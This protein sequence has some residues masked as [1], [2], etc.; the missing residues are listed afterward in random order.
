MKQHRLTLGLA[1]LVP[2]LLTAC[3][4]NEPETS[5]SAPTSSA[6]AAVPTASTQTTQDQV[7][8]SNASDVIELNWDALI[9]ADW[10]LDKLMEEYNAASLSDDDP[11]AGALMEKIKRSSKEAPVVHD[12]DGK[13]VKLPGFVVPLEIDVNAIHEFLL[14]PYFGACIHV[15]PPPA[16]QTVYVVTDEGHAYPG[17]LF[18][19]VW[20]TGKMTVERVESERGDAGYRIQAS[21]VE[22][23][24]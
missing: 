7:A 18:D 9:P 13:R 11:R 19:T 1:L 5:L 12:Y 21:K 23:Y 4:S 10:R 14:V 8:G 15:P 16:N 22:R 3:D 2:M 24:R 17:K 20:V 6:Q